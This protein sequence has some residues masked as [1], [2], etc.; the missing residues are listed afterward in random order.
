MRSCRKRSAGS[1]MMKEKEY[2]DFVNVA[3]L[4]LAVAIVALHSALVPQPSLVMALICR[5][6]VPYFFVA[7]GF[8]LQRKCTGDQVG[9]AVKGYIRRL[10]LPYAVFSVIW[11]VQLLV[12]DAIRQIGFRKAAVLLIQYII[13]NPQG[14]LWYVWASI[15]GALMLYP[16]IKR[17][18]LLQALPLGIALFMIGLLANT[19]YFAIEGSV[20]LK[21]IVD[22]Y[23]RVFLVSNNAPFVGFVYLLIGMIISEHYE[24][25]REKISLGTG[26]AVFAVSCVVHA[27]EVRLI[28][29]RAT[30]VGDGAFY[31]SQLIYV[32]AVFFLTTRIRCPHLGKTFVTTAKWLSTGIYFLHLPILWMIHRTATYVLPRIPGLKRIASLFD[33]PSVCFTGCMILCLAICLLAYRKPKSFVCRILK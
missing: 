9:N 4:F 12:D 16:I 28:G 6:A 30:I 25:L 18:W 27:C 17:K 2:F 21:S 26:I 15:I 3:K 10:F 7:S 20:W 11:I 33:H 32:P 31:L 5:L 13:F 1:E 8:F 19:Y 29:S 24:L 22:G 14:G 23:L